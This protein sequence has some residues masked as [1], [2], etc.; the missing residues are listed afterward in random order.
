M[1]FVTVNPLR[2]TAAVA[3]VI[4]IYQQAFG[5]APWNEGWRCNECNN[6]VPLNPTPSTCTKCGKG[7]MS[8]YW[9]YEKV[10]ADFQSEMRRPNALCVQVTADD[11][12]P[13]AFAW[14]YEVQGGDE[15]LDAH[16]DA[17]NLHAQ[18]SGTF[19]YLDE[20]AVHPHHQRRGVGKQLAKEVLTQQRNER[21]LLRTLEDSQM[22]RLVL[23]LGGSKILSISRGRVILKLARTPHHQ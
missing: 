6:V 1:R 8:E 14:G 23:S 19:F 20:L 4:Q 7:P 17:P 22:H 13:V 9:P 10:L 21:I 12:T 5:E 18:L 2:D 16:L 15:E 3:S 11:S